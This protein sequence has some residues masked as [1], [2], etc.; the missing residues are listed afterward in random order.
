MTANR[1]VAK[2]TAEEIAEVESPELT[3][4]ELASL[5][6]ASDALPP[7]LFAALTARKPGQRGPQKSPTKKMI[8]IRLD[9][10]VVA[11]FRATGE[12][13]Q[14]RMN[15]VL[16]AALAPRGEKIGAKSIGAEK[17][18]ATQRAKARRALASKAP[19]KKRA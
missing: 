15:Q 18:P 17:A 8:T 1:E 14:R 4:E 13:W 12:G 10:E 19:A 6:P 5:R 2:F 9:P 3:D 7:K 16:K 11:G